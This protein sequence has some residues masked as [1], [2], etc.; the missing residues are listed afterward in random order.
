MLKIERK[1]EQRTV[2]YLLIRRGFHGNTARLNLDFVTEFAPDSRCKTVDKLCH[3]RHFAE[4]DGIGPSSSA[5]IYPS[6]H[7]YLTAAAQARSTE[8]SEVPRSTAIVM[9]RA[10]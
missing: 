10:R 3:C 1:R 7:A 6:F 2:F 9:S 8:V 4:R 5:D